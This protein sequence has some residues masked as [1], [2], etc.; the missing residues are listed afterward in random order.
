MHSGVDSGLQQHQQPRL[1][2][3]CL[4]LLA[5]LYMSC[6]NCWQSVGCVWCW[7]VISWFRVHATVLLS[8]S[9][10]IPAHMHS[11][12]FEGHTSQLSIVRQRI[13][14]WGSLN[15]TYVLQVY[16]ET[17]VGSSAAV[18]RATSLLTASQAADHCGVALPIVMY[19]GVSSGSTNMWPP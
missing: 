19:I 6:Y 13:I 4:A 17:D 15:L 8:G 12:T 11:K 10:C 9:W 7:D 18:E 5:S 14:T 1:L 2:L 3:S 16:H